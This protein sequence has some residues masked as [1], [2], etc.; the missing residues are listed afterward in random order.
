MVIRKGNSFRTQT[1]YRGPRPSTPSCNIQLQQINMLHYLVFCMSIVTTSIRNL[2]HFFVDQINWSSGNTFHMH[3][4]L[5][6]SQ[7]ASLQGKKRQD[8]HN[9]EGMEY[10]IDAQKPIFNLLEYIYQVTAIN[11]KVSRRQ[12]MSMT[13]RMIQL[14]NKH[15]N[16]D[17]KGVNNPNE[18]DLGT[19]ITH[20]SRKPTCLTPTASYTSSI[21]R[22]L[23]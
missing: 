10:R 13:K 4:Q 12:P 11:H 18:I 16:T 7:L 22:D 15:T 23:R 8:F 6:F 19:Y 14:S 1:S 9:N 3:Q 21:L 17:S 20:Y 2:S 5:I